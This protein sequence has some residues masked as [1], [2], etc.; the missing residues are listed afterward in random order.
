MSAIA[1]VPSDFLTALGTLRK[2]RCRSELRLEEI[3]APSRLAPFAVALGAEVTGEVAGAGIVAGPGGV[4][5][6][7][8]GAGRV[9][10]LKS[11]HGPAMLAAPAQPSE[12]AT[13]R[14]ILLHDPEGSALWDGTFRIVT[15]IRAELEA[16]IGNDA[17]LG[18]VAWT[19]L[20]DALENNAAPY[21]AAGGTATRILSESYGSLAGRPDSVEV[22]LRA[23]WTPVSSDVG[24]HL[25]AWSEMVCSF[26][27]LPPLPEGV[28]ALPGRRLN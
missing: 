10:S 14:F 1:Q 2:A 13:G 23:S 25:R 21:R 6:G 5:P 16:D 7:G 3:P 19:W 17:M 4:R 24:A 20:V 11:V 12:L 15:Y 22:E 9:R 26:A 28:T 27:G 8:P 18:S